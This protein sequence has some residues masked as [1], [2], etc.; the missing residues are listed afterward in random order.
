MKK[1]KLFIIIICCCLSIIAFI[2]SLKFD[3][4]GTPNQLDP[5]ILE[6]YTESESEPIIESPNIKKVSEET[7]SESDVIGLTIIEDTSS[8]E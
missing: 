2:L 4:P 6:E 1:D 5:I 8:Y 3:I 7:L